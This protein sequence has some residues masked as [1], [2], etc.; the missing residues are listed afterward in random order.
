MI[1][2]YM[3]A[4]NEDVILQ[5]TIDHYRERFPT[6]KFTIYDNESTDKTKEIA[7]QNGC[8]VVNWPTNNQVNEYKITELKNNCWKNA[9]TDWVLV[10]DPDELLDINEQ[11]LKEEETKGFTVIKSEGWNMV[12]MKDNYD[13]ANIK[14]GTRVSQYDKAYLFNKKFINAINYSHGCHSCSPSG[15]FKKSDTA[16]KLYHYKCINPDYLVQR[17]KWTAARLSDANKKAGMGSYWLEAN[18][19]NIKAGFYSGRE[20]ARLNKVKP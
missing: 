1:H 20:Q 15:L 13:L 12:N 17:F 8:E 19:A 5:Y 11:Q 6:A 4:Y 3:I 14:H 7:L 9:T 10:C 18:E 2:I 16:Y